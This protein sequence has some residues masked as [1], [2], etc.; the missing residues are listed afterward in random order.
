METN[1]KQDKQLEDYKNEIDKLLE[2]YKDEVV[3]SELMKATHGKGQ[4]VELSDD[5]DCEDA[6]DHEPKKME[7]E[8]PLN[9]SKEHTRIS[10]LKELISN[11]KEFCIN[12][13][14]LDILR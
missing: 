3:G 5:Q 4:T 1:N 13:E 10:Y 11:S 8:V 9:I 14:H 12:N 6:D 2:L 7:C